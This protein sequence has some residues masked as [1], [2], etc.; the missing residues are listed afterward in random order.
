MFPFATY[1]KPIN[2]ITPECNGDGKSSALYS[3]DFADSLLKEIGDYAKANKIRL[4]MHP[5]Q[6]CVLSSKSEDV[7]INAFSELNHHCEILDRMGL[8]KDS[9]IIIHGGG[10][11]GNKVNH[12]NVWKKI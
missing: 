3:L 11:Y 9:V 6:F 5:A 10:V 12:W 2:G 1:T 8:G 4:T 7:V